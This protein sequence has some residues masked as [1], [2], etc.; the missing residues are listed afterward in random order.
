LDEAATTAPSS[1]EQ[2]MDDRALVHQG[3]DG[4]DGGLLTCRRRLRDEDRRSPAGCELRA[5]PF[6]PLAHEAR[7][8]GDDERTTRRGGDEHER[9][10]VATR[11]PCGSGRDQAGRRGNPRRSR[12]RRGR[13]SRPLFERPPSTR[14]SAAAPRRR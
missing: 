12:W 14:W 8:A 9:V 13:T 5:S 4:G 7:H 3:M 2:E 6:A 11:L 1:E 10:D